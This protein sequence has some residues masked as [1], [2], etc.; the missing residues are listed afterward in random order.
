VNLLLSSTLRRTE[1]L[2]GRQTESCSSHTECRQ[3]RTSDTLRRVT[4]TDSLLIQK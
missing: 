3:L 1:Q 2:D 4:K